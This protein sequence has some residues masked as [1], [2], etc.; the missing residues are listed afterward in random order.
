MNKTE[1]RQL[2]Q[3]ELR[4][5]GNIIPFVMLDMYDSEYIEWLEKK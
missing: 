1:L 5:D 4:K 3:K 2:Y